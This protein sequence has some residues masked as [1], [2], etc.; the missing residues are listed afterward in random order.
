MSIYSDYKAGALND[1]EFRQ[2]CMRENREED[3]V[4]DDGY[5]EREEEYERSDRGT[6]QDV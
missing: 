4:I 2:A 3:L 1:F 6:V 5:D